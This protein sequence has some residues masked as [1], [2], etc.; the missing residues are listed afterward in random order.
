MSRAL[1]TRLEKVERL[2]PPPAPRGKWHRVIGDSKAELATKRAALI[3]SPEW[4]EGDNTIERLIVDP[5]LLN[6]RFGRS[7]TRGQSLCR[8]ASCLE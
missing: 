3:A 8:S 1:Q 4:Q 2:M 7:W 6:K 5:Q